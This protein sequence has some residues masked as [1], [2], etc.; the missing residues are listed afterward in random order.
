MP[1]STRIFLLTLTLFLSTALA[2]D[3]PVA[4]LINDSPWLAGFEAL[5]AQYEE[6]TGNQVEL[7]VTPFPGMLQKSRNAVTANESEFDLINLNEGWYT[8]FYDAGLVTPLLEID[9]EYELDPAIIEYDYATRWDPEVSYS[10]EDGTLY[11]LPING[12]IQLFYYRTDLFEE[13]GL[14]PPE[15][16]EDVVAAAEQFHNPPQMLGLVNRTSPTWWELQGY[17]ESYGGGVLSL[18]EESGEWRV[19]LDSP[20]S[21]EGVTRWLELNQTFGPNNYANVGQAEAI[22]LMA[23]GRAAMTLLVSA[24]APNLEDPEQSVVIGQ[25]GSTVLPRPASGEHA[26]MSG[27]WVMGVPQNLPDARKQAAF[28][29]LKYATSK[30]AQ[31][32]YARAGGIPTRQDVYEELG[33]EEDFEWMAAVADSTP[34]IKGLPRVAES[35]QIT[36]VLERYAGQVL[37]GEQS[38]E[39]MSQAAEEVRTIL[40][41]GGY[42]LAAGDAN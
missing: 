40:R 7:N 33:Q 34:Y 14:E 20:E 24:A 32:D 26:T 29:F 36:D 31:L 8:Q 16:W 6:E 9:P 23:S 41:E 17:M 30:D 15:T 18:D 2:Q 27:I 25:V 3:R 13:A 12:N 39:A 28:D 10:T 19:L 1:Q 38:P 5:V 21:I 42:T 4:I 22:S 37:L 11:G 35:A